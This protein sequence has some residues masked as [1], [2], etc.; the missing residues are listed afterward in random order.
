MYPFKNESYVYPRNAWYVGAWSS[1]V[2]RDLFER[3]ILGQP[4]LFYRTELG[5]AV[6][7]DGRCPHRNYPLPRG[8]LVGDHVQCQ[9]HG[10]EYDSSGTCVRIPSQDRVPSGFSARVFH[11]VEKWQWVWI[12]LGDPALADETDIP[13]HH[14]LGLEDDLWDPVVGDCHHLAA[15]YQL[16]NENVLDLTHLSYTHAKTIGTEA[17]VAGSIRTE[18]LPTCYRSIRETKGDYA[19]AFHNR[20]MG[21][22]GAFDREFTIDFYAPTLVN[23]GTRFWSSGQTSTRRILREFNVLHAATPDT[24]TTTH[25]FWAWTRSFSVGDVSISTMITGGL[26]SVIE[27]DRIALEAQERAISQGYLGRSLS[28]AADVAALRARQV[29]EDMIRSEMPR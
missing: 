22:T 10:W 16:L 26:A 1:E 17:V 6:A 23:A 9:Y 3:T 5:T 8:L 21:I 2:N 11:V 13:D 27:E 14:A 12:W 19:T 25:Y 24:P 28:A 4:I 18:Q 7:M 20:V 29:I 15:R